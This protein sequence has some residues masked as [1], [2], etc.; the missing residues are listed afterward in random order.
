MKKFVTAF[1]VLM[2][3]LFISLAS[4]A[5]PAPVTEYRYELDAGGKI[6]TAIPY[7]NGKITGLMIHY[8]PDGKIKYLSTVINGVIEGIQYGYFESGKLKLVVPYKNNKQNGL[9]KVFKE[10]G[11]LMAERLYRDGQVVPR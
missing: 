8:Y 1:T 5:N 3:T 4:F 10:D 6:K 7:T 9:A 2:I 11:T